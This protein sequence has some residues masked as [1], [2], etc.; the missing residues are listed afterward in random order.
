M[1][2]RRSPFTPL[3]ASHCLNF[4]L[5]QI[6]QT[7]Q[8]RQDGFRELWFHWR[9]L[10][11]AG[12]RCRVT[13]KPWM[14]ASKLCQINCHMTSWWVMTLFKIQRK[15]ENSKIHKSSLL[16]TF[17]SFIYVCSTCLIWPVSLFLF[18]CALF[19]HT[20]RYHLA[21]W[22]L[23]PV[24]WYTPTRSQ[25]CWVITGSPSALPSKLKKLLITGWNVS[26]FLK[27]FFHFSLNTYRVTLT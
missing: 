19:F 5:S 20:C 2:N 1:E 25:C 21:L 27:L 4:D 15:G 16:Y 17:Y 14:T 13:M 8:I 11:F 3:F 18:S 9:N 22:P 26:I 7:H 10:L 12:R 6:W 24:S 23:C